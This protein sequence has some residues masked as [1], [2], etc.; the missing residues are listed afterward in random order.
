MGE[1]KSSYPV[2]MREEKNP[3]GKKNGFENEEF[4][5]WPQGGA[6]SRTELESKEKKAVLLQILIHR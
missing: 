4:Y 6:N 3:T 5:I 2:L 1:N